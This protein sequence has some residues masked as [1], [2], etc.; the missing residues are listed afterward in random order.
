MPLG[1]RLVFVAISL[2]ASAAN[3]APTTTETSSTAA[4]TEQEALAT[5]RAAFEYRDFDVVIESLDP[6]VHPPRIVDVERMVEA[7]RLLGVAMFVSGNERGAR[8]EFAQLLLLDP[9]HKLDAFVIPPRVIAAFEDV[10]SQLRPKLQRPKPARPASSLPVVVA[11]VSPP[12]PALAFLPFGIPQAVLGEPASGI[13][14]GAAQGL[15]LAANI[16]GFV[17]ANRVRRD[18]PEFDTWTAVQ[19]AGLG[20]LTAAYGASVV[21]SQILIGQQRRL[22]SPRPSGAS[23][24]GLSL[25]FDPLVEF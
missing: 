14:L 7:R 13:T 22:V 2:G 19:Y 18:S 15:G 11:E 6:W 24:L 12:H 16:L 17:M 23:S 9:N 8:E 5:A 25:P 21:Q 4:E 10:R 3:G 20:T 1:V